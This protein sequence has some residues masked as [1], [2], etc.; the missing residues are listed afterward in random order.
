MGIPLKGPLMIR[1]A[2]EKAE[3]TK[4]GE[5]VEIVT[6]PCVVC[7]TR[8]TFI[9]NRIDYEAWQTSTHI[10]NAFPD[11]SADEREILISGTCPECWD[12]LWAPMEDE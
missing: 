4:N 6:R 7:G 3:F 5:G 8:H 2:I 12:I 1:G 11:M 10:Q 9:L